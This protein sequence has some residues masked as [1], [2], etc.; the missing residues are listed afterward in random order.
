M[1]AIFHLQIYLTVNHIDIHV[2]IAMLAIATAYIVVTAIHEGLTTFAVVEIVDIS[3]YDYLPAS[4]T[5][6]ATLELG[7]GKL[8]F[9][10]LLFVRTVSHIVSL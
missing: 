8:V 1:G 5:L 2:L 7:G 4:T 9:V 10:I 6:D 3:G